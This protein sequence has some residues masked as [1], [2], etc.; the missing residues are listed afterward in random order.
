MPKDNRI[1]ESDALFLQIADLKLREE[2]GSRGAEAHPP[3]GQPDSQPGIA[4]GSFNRH[5]IL[6][7]I[8]SLKEK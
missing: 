7:L 2:Q 5:T 3:S 4:Q 6:R 1:Y 8:R